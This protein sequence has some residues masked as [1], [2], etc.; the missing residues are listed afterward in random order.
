MADKPRCARLAS[1]CLGFSLVAIVAAAQ[2]WGAPLLAADLHP[3]E[4]AS[5]ALWNGEAAEF[6][7]LASGDFQV[8]GAIPLPGAVYFAGVQRL[9]EALDGLSVEVVERRSSDRELTL[10][11]RLRGVQGRPLVWEPL[12]QPVPRDWT[13]VERFGLENGLVQSVEVSL[14]LGFAPPAPLDTGAEQ[15]RPAE[16][17][18]RFQPGQFPECLAPEPDGSVLVAMLHSD[19]LWRVST[20]GRLSVAARLPISALP[21]AGIICLDRA[22][23]G[24]LYVTV[25][26]DEAQQGLWQVS[27][28]GEARRLAILAQDS[29]PNGLDVDHEGWV[30]IADSRGA[31]WRWRPGQARAELWLRH[32]WLAPRPFTAAAPGTN[33]VRRVGMAVLA[34]V[35]DSAR[36]VRIGMDLQGRA[37]QPEVLAEG[38]PG[39][40]FAVAEDGTLYVATHPFNTILALSP[41]GTRSTIAGP[42]QGAIGST[43]VAVI[44]GQPQTLLFTADGGLFAPVA[45]VAVEPKLV[46]LKLE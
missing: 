7:R 34:T 43:A 21:G 36:V 44:E 35:S 29:Q 1:R 33:G 19:A 30:W 39:D 41:D 26:G 22:R 5:Q 2:G 25:S 32:P 3:V 11:R 20:D 9:R 27:P 28:G 17:L 24:T 38:V 46:R 18:A 37:A 45:G 6:Q 10:T 23:D 14:D 15:F 12:P 13:L 8:A 16:V 42:A 40:D 4:V 31:I